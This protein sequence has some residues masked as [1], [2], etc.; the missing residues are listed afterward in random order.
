MGRKKAK[1]KDSDSES[2]EDDWEEVEGAKVEDSV[3]LDDYHPELPK[4]GVEIVVAEGPKLFNKKKGKKK[5]N[6]DEIIRQQLNRM[7]RELQVEMHKTNLLCLIARG[8]Y[9]NNLTYDK[10]LLSL[11]LSY[12]TDFTFDLKNVKL[13]FLR[14]FSDWFANWFSLAKKTRSKVDLL[15]S[16]S[17]SFES[18][19]ATHPLE[20][21]LMFLILLRT[22]SPRIQCRLCC[23]FNPIPIKCDRLVLSD[24]QKNR[25]IQN[26]DDGSDD[27]E[28]PSKSSDSKKGQK[29][30]SKNDCKPSTSKARDSEIE[31]DDES[32]TKTSKKNNR[33]VKRK[34]ERSDVS[35]V[36]P[37]ETMVNTRSRRCKAAASVIEISDED[38]APET[39]KKVQS[40]KKGSSQTSK[41]R[42]GRKQKNE[43]D[44]EPETKKDLKK[45]SKATDQTSK[46]RRGQKRKD[47]SDEEYKEEEDLKKT[48]ASKKPKKGAK[49]KEN[50]KKLISSDD[51]D[52]QVLST[53]EF[54]DHLECWIEIYVDTEERWVCLLPSEKLFDSP[55]EIEKFTVHPLIYVVAFDN[56]NH[57]KD[58]TQR[59]SSEYGSCKFRRA[60]VEEI[61]W[62]DALSS[63]RP[64]RRTKQE[65]KE[66]EEISEEFARRPMPQ[67]LSDFKNHPLYILQKHLLKY[68]VIYPPNAP[69]VGHFRGEAVYARE[70]V[71]DVHSRD[72]WIRHARVVRPN[73]EPYK[74]TTR[75]K[76][77]DKNLGGFLHDLP[78]EL[79]GEWQTGPY[80]PPVAKDGKVPRN[81]FGNVE[82]FQPCMLPIGCVHLKLPGLAR[83]ANKL[84]IDC[85]PAVVGFDQSRAGAHPVVEGF[86]VCEEFKDIL[87]AAWDEEQENAKV[88]DQSRREK[89]VLYN[90][91]RLIK[92]LLIR[93]Q[94]KEKYKMEMEDEQPS[95]PMAVETNGDS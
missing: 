41:T 11:A 15:E 58:L 88:R 7:K 73:Q 84:K 24:K 31:S 61:W 46:T 55:K 35:Y 21:C 50:P 19:I 92:G 90:W 10:S 54:D 20:Y 47:I 65:R 77:W 59:Y 93:E 68:E 89:R 2:E 25:S 6:V 1:R 43:S 16:L 67:S 23:S 78:Q 12:L 85:V 64:R 71:R 8:F 74:I 34:K 49:S 4:E 32:T 86:V 5:V 26:H 51:D 76:K 33:N 66:D 44:E 29:S 9:L 81:Q 60:R 28:K 36:K 3:D 53:C 94:L 45:A 62:K 95:R 80:V 75:K 82:L 83:V 17:R 14:Q 39:S 18:R 56:F 38:S 52:I 13:L 48:P 91:R 30:K 57:V 42:K 72:Y 40:S 69:P 63:F 79:F 70:C 22:Y 87:I 27:T 37:S